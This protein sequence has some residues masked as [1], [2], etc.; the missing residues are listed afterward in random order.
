MNEIAAA[1]EPAE[2]EALADF[3]AASERPQRE[4]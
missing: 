3:L 4:P 2:R 1:L